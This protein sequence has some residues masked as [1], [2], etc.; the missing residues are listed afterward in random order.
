LL[1]CQVGD[2]CK[3]YDEEASEDALYPIGFPYDISLIRPAKQNMHII[4]D[5]KSPAPEWY[6]DGA[7]DTRSKLYI[8]GSHQIDGHGLPRRWVEPVGQGI[9]LNQAGL[10]SDQKWKADD[11]KRL[12]S[13]C[14]LWRPLNA[15]PGW[16]G[17]SGAPVIVRKEDN[18]ESLL[19]FQSF[20][21][22]SH[23]R[24]FAMPDDKLKAGCADGYISFGAC[25]KLPEDV[26]NSAIV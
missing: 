13:R 1:E 5:I 15:A 18:T 14:T 16:D 7:L 3:T 23:H 19:G 2:L 25:M 10:P 17:W 4:H 24:Q 8:I 12:V 26:L 9:I 11:V 21:Q 22:D 6:R 20:V